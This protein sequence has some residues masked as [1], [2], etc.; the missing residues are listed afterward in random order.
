MKR[1]VLAFL[2]CMI[3]I[4]AGCAMEAA[5]PRQDTISAPVAEESTA[6]PGSYG[7]EGRNHKAMRPVEAAFREVRI[8]RT[9][10]RFTLSELKAITNATRLAPLAV[11]GCDLE[12]IKIFVAA[13][14]A[15]VV[16]VRS[17]VG[18]K[19]VRAVIGYDDSEERVILIDPANYTKAPL[20]RVEYSDFA[21]RWDDPQKTCLLMFPEHVGEAR[22]RN[23]LKQ[24]L[25]EEKMN[26][27]QIMTTRRS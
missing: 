20:A 3:I 10:E 12:V 11:S 21:K 25:S 15:P 22:I 18:P 8:L 2:I 14:W 13:S 5:P 1:Q 9:A 6:L 27:I 16:F 23:V 17:P 26:S 4:C 19:H 24:Y 7:T